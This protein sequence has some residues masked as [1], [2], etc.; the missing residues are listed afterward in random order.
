M[1]EPE[2]TDAW[3]GKE[4][5][6]IRVARNVAGRSLLVLTEVIVGLTLLPF[7]VAHLG[8]SEYGLWLLTASVTNYFSVLD[9]GYGG[10]LVKFVAQYRSLRQ[11]RAI[12]EIVSTVFVMFAAIGAV[13]YLIAVVVAF[14]LGRF[15]PL[16]PDQAA[17]GRDI[18]LMTAL[19]VALGFPFGV[20]G[21]VMNGFQRYDANSVVAVGLSIVVAIANLA[22]LSMGY[23]L[24]ELVAVTTLLRIAS[25]FI[26]R[27]NAY[28]AF[29]LLRV[30]LGL[31][32]RARLHEVTGF[33][34]Y[35]MVIGFSQKLNY[36]SDPAII[37][38]FL[39]SGAVA[40]WGVAERITSATQRATNQLNTVL[41]PLIVD[42]DAGQRPERV[43]RILVIG[44]RLSIAVVGAVT[45]CLVI[46]ADVL[47]HS[48][49]GKG[50]DTSARVLQVLALAIAVRVSQATSMTLLK[51]TGLHRLAAWTNLGTGV[52]NIG[53]S[54]VLIQRYGLVGQAVGT[55]IPAAVGT[56]LVTIPAA[57]RRSGLPIARFLTRAV[58]P[59]VWPAVPVAL[60][61]LAAKP[62][63]PARLLAVGAASI[64]GAGLYLLLFSITGIDA[65][66]R[67]Y[68]LRLLRQ[69]W[70]AGLARAQKVA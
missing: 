9:L 28:W 17:L 69:R 22:I 63:V 21:A 43:R 20:F 6:A 24:R 53:L 42:S 11:P 65:N 18:L 36:S 46:F 62:F 70:T 50:F 41:F 49:V 1:N 10:A 16:S 56:V 66:L 7:N 34:V 45:V 4:P 33:S 31:V 61:L 55:L 32:R 39:G 29:P 30:R 35:S 26:Y 60:L 47:V 2:Q 44:T 5:A 13:A 8:K 59:A 67:G 12:N 64:L 54:I 51:G 15:F 58:W 14:N 38:A 52:A 25:L 48:W 19:F 37:A 57:C 3:V 40:L 68:Y 23:G 27:A